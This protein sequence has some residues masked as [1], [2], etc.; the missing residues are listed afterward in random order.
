[1]ADL[2]LKQALEEYE[3]ECG[4]VLGDAAKMYI[5]TWVVD[6]FDNPP[7]F[8]IGACVVWLAGK[9]R[10][11]YADKNDPIMHEWPDE[12]LRFY[13]NEVREHMQ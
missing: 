1:M 7:Y 3:A 12:P 13:L 11:R 8:L 2:T 5:D 10:I 4:E 6:E 9:D